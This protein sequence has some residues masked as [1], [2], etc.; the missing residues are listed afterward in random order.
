MSKASETTADIQT[1]MQTSGHSRDINTVELTQADVL[2]TDVPAPWEVGPPIN[3]VNS[4]NGTTQS[5]IKSIKIAKTG[6][7]EV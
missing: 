1:Q 7:T 5:F 2:G 3:N 6:P 4:N